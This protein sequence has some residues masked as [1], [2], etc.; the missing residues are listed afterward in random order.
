MERA[1]HRRLRALS[2]AEREVFLLDARINE[3]GVA[4]D[5]ELVEAA[6]ALVAETQAQL[7][8]EMRR[9]TGGVVE[10]ATQSAR[11]LTWLRARGVEADSVDKPAVAELLGTDL[12]DDV[13][14]VLEV[15]AEAARSSTAKLKAFRARTCRDGRLRDNLLYHGAGT[16]RWSGRGVQ[17]QNLPRPSI[18]VD[19]EAAIT[20]IRQR[21]EAW[22]IDAFY[23]PP[24]GVVSDCL[25]GMLIASPGMELIAA[26]F[27]AIE[28]RVLAW[29]RRAAGSDP[30]VRH[31]R[32]CLPPHGG[33]DLRPVRRCHR[34]GLGRAPARQ[35]GRAR[36][37][38][39]TWRAQVPDD[40][41]QG[42]HPH[43]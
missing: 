41:R 13:R 10:A 7:D 29:L 11:L 16:G 36:V 21:E 20:A 12:P 14:R 39:R 18:V 34:Q 38:V 31:G 28:A 23:G 6:E 1:L 42:R 43:R 8:A 24:M 5:L 2:D 33:R 9:L 37:R 32:R 26:D 27:A 25:R 15:R 35:T 30:A 3:R 17:L 22:W 4:V 19:T 40:L